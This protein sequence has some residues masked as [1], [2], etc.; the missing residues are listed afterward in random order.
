M[1]DILEERLIALAERLDVRTDEQL[2]AGVL[3]RLDR[4][5]EHFERRPRRRLALV[6]AAAVVAVTV[7]LLLAPGPRHTIAHWF[8]VGSTRIEPPTTVAPTTAPATTTSVVSTVAAPPSTVEPDT[9]VVPSATFPTSL[10]LGPATTPADAAARTGLPVPLASSLGAPI[11]VF[12]VSPPATGQVAVL[13]PPSASLPR[14]DVG[15]VG[16]LISSMPGI[17]AEGLFLKTEAEG[18]TIESFD[19]VNGAGRTVHAIW[20]SGSPHGYVF[21]GRDGSPVFDTLRLATNT[22]LWQDGLVTYRLEASV[23][24]E[25]AVEIATSIG[26]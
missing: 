14:S 12:V 2:V 10:D 15:G 3:A 17:I 26:S 20:L 9:S 25:R 5:D 1:S 6:T 22:L 8:G 23:P 19:F 13:Y 21:Q 7:V 11:G 16:A 18:T 24:R 4:T